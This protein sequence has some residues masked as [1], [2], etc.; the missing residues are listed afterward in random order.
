[1]FCDGIVQ[2][3]MKASDSADQIIKTTFSFPNTCDK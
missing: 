2:I 1:M 3:K